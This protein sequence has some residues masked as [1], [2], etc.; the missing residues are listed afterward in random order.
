MQRD[1]EALEAADVL[2]AIE[3]PKQLAMIER[4]PGQPARPNWPAPA[5]ARPT[6]G[7][8]EVLQDLLERV[9]GRGHA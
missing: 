9:I 1:G 6:G 2:R 8:E 3:P 5:M 4:E 7:E